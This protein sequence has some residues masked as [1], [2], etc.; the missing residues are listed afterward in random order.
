MPTETALVVAGIVC[1]FA[2]FAISLAWVDYYCRGVRTPGAQY[3]DT[4]A[5]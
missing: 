5:E 1:V 3:F 2:S 4:P